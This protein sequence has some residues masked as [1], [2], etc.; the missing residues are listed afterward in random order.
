[1]R[2]KQIYAFLFAF[3]LG[4]FFSHA[5]FATDETAIGDI[6]QE[7]LFESL[8]VE[9][10][11]DLKESEVMQSEINR[12]FTKAHLYQEGVCYDQDIGK[13]ISLYEEVIEISNEE[14]GF[15][16]LFGSALQLSWL[17]FEGPQNQRDSAR[18]EFMIKQS[19]LL[20]AGI[21]KEDLQELYEAL[22][23]KDGDYADRYRS[24][25]V[26]F[27][28]AQA[29]STYERKKIADDLIAQGF[30]STAI[31]YDPYLERAIKESKKYQEQ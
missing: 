29:R 30:K 3:L 12:L 21:P 18:A 9:G 10:C 22:A 13:A 8:G 2:M 26:S 23:K 27:S 14:L 11:A 28:K 16:L 17:Y 7:Q 1:M 25:V 4:L 24:A 19:A 31:I 20:L 15:D 5:S 6:T